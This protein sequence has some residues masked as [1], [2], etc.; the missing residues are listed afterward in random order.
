VLLDKHS[1]YLDRTLQKDDEVVDAEFKE[2]Q[3]LTENPSPTETEG[4]PPAIAA[5]PSIVPTTENENS[6]DVEPQ[7]R[8]Q[9]AQ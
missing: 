5:S 6:H 7:N 8:S 1:A 2:V 4:P 9:S 3:V